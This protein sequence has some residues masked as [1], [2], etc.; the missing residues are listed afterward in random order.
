MKRIHPGAIMLIHSVSSDNAEAL[1]RVIE[2]AQKQGYE[3]KSLMI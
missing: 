1:P 2:D 3:F